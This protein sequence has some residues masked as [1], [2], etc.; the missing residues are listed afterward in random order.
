MIIKLWFIKL[1]YFTFQLKH[2]GIIV[3]TKKERKQIE[4]Q[5]TDP[6]LKFYEDFTLKLRQKTMLK[7]LT[8][9]SKIG[10]NDAFESAILSSFFDI[11]FHILSAYIKNIK[12]SSKIKINTSTVFNENVFLVYFF[13]KFSIS[14]FDV[15]V[16]FFITIFESKK[17]K[18]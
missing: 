14:I 12:P 10:T 17:K 6:K 3:R 8:I 9:F 1:E 5:F 11:F 4:Y 15:F 13:S 16:S 2:S 7:Q 18:V